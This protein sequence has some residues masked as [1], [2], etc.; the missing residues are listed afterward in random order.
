M[1]ILTQRK[2]ITVDQDDHNHY[3]KYEQSMDAE[4]EDVGIDEDSTYSIGLLG[5]D[6]QHCFELHSSNRCSPH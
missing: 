3:S 1:T 5:K 2:L 6:S 4:T